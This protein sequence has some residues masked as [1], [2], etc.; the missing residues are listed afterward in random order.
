MIAEPP[1]PSDAGR[2]PGRDHLAGRLAHHLGVT[3]SGETTPSGDLQWA[4][5]LAVADRKSVV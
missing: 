1:K 4:A 5:H 3:P 2:M